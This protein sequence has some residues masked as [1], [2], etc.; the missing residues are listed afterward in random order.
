MFSLELRCGEFQCLATG[1]LSFENLS[2]VRFVLN[3]FKVLHDTLRYLGMKRLMSNQEKKNELSEDVKIDVIWG[4]EKCVSL[5]WTTFRKSH[6]CENFGCFQKCRIASWI[7]P[8]GL[9]ASLRV[10]GCST[11]PLH[12]F[13]EVCEMINKSWSFGLKCICFQH[14]FGGII[15]SKNNEITLRALPPVSTLTVHWR[16]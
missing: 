2:S 7:V 14:A 1:N 5:H 12:R 8:K 6:L 3:C 11:N 13:C 16:L 15:L 9:D 10:F 4:I